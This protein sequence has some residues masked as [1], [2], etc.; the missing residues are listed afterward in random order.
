VFVDRVVCFVCAGISK[1]PNA[2]IF[3]VTELVQVDKRELIG[4]VVGFEGVWPI[5][6]TEEGLVP[7]Q[8]QIRIQPIHLD[9]LMRQC[10]HSEDTDGRHSTADNHN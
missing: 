9:I 6:S 8:W 5:T 1:G 3:R 10:S 2:Y 7:S 4:Y